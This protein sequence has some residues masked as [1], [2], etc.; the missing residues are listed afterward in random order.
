[1]FI[2]GV[3]FLLMSKR[4]DFQGAKVNLLCIHKLVS[5]ICS[6]ES[7]KMEVGKSENYLI[8]Q[9]LVINLNVNEITTMGSLIFMEDKM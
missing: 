5:S 9:M 1:M 7:L 3:D 6:F 2:D 4:G 8:I